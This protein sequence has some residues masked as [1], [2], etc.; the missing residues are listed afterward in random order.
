MF[1]E[2]DCDSVPLENVGAES[3]GTKLLEAFE[4]VLVESKNILK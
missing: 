2:V 4:G 3:E 1:D